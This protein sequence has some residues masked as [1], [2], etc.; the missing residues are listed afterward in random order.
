MFLRGPSQGLASSLFTFTP[1]AASVQGNGSGT[2]L[3]KRFVDVTEMSVPVVLVL[4]LMEADS[5]NSESSGLSSI[6][7]KFYIFNI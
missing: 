7:Q 4:L 6:F 5:P 3:R 2:A 1:R